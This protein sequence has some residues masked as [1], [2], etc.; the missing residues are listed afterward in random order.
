MLR[1]VG[2]LLLLCFIVMPVWAGK[3]A[4]APKVYMDANQTID[5][6]RKNNRFIIKLKTTPGTGYSWFL[7]SYNSNFI[8]LQKHYFKAAGKAHPGSSGYS[9]WEFKVLDKAF[10]GPHL[11]YINFVYTQPWNLKGKQVQNFVVATR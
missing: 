5:T 11:F 3:K 8:S 10:V 2:F 9:Y 1:R 4:D 6:S 7:T